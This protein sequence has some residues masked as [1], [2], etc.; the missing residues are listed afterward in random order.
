MLHQLVS[1]RLRHLGFHLIQQ[2]DDVILHRAS[3]SSLIVNE[4]RLLMV[5]HHVAR[6]EVT[7]HEEIVRRLGE[8]SG[9]L[10]ELVLESLF[11][12]DD[13]GVGLD[14]VVFEVVEVIHHR[15]CVE[16]GDGI[17]LAVVQALV[18]LDLKTHQ[19]FQD[20]P[21]HP[22]G[23]L[24]VSAAAKGL[25]HPS[26]EGLVSMVRLEVAVAFGIDGQQFGDGK[27]LGTEMSRQVEESLVLLDVGVVG[28]YE[29]GV[30]GD[31]AVVFSGGTGF[32]DGL[33]VRRAD[34]D[35]L[36]E[37]KQCVLDVV[38]KHG[39]ASII[40]GQ[41]YKRKFLKSEQCPLFITI[42]AP[43]FVNL[44]IGSLLLVIQK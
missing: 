1:E 23:V 31:D 25:L 2:G 42:F 34:P 4:I 44:C 29:R 5:D 19:G 32:S 17:D 35:G 18:S 30:G 28:A 6:L 7:V 26:E 8:I 27:A 9:Q 21:E 24:V 43:V 16:A 33:D 13:L 10:A 15:G 12:E 39:M 11:V 22:D 37:L 36:S 41:I 14:E 20:L 38:V 40:N 3:S